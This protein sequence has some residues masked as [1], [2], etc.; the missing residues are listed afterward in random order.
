MKLKKTTSLLES[1]LI[2]ATPIEE[3]KISTNK[4]ITSNPLEPVE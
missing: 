3:P 1:I 2:H 4:E